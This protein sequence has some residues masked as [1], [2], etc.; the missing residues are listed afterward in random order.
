M[1]KTAL[2]LGDSKRVIGAFPRD[3]R[4]EA[5]YQLDAVQGTERRLSRNLPG[6]LA[7][8]G[9]GAECVPEKDAVDAAP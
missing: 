3:A 7:R 4:R 5:G 1:K 6:E 8:C 2:F 9:V